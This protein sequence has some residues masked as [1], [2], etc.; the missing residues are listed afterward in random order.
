MHAR[1]FVSPLGKDRS[2]TLVE[3]RFHC[4]SLKRDVSHIV[5]QYHKC[6]L[7]KA[8]KHNIGLYLYTPL[9]IP[10][11]PW[12]WRDVSLDIVLALPRTSLTH[13]SILVI[14]D[15]FSKM[16]HSIAHTKIDYA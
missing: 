15:R 6:Q 14:V 10:H 3:D 11:T 16:A 5:S 13:D 8:K 9:P 4:P 7:A 1:G 12:T 2:I